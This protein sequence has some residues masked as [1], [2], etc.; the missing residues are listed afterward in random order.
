MKLAEAAKLL[1]TTEQHLH[2]LHWSGVGPKPS[3]PGR[4][5]YWSPDFTDAEL[6]AWKVGQG[7]NLAPPPPPPAPRSPRHRF[8]P[9]G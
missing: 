6:L 8:K 4:K 2:A 9:K 5:I 7:A 3:E 1:G